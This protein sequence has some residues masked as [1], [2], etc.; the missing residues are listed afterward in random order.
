MEPKK[1]VGQNIKE[2]RR[3]AGLTQEQLGH[4]C[5]MLMGDIS[6]VERGKR[7]VRVSTVSRI[8]EGLGVDAS[9]LLRG[10]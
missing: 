3:R 10:A 6:R 5:G 2:Q 8:A 9:E 4:R 1:I 7:D